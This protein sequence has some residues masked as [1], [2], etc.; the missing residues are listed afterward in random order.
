[1]RTTAR[2]AASGGRTVSRDPGETSL[3]AT[4]VTGR[5]PV[6]ILGRVD[7]LFGQILSFEAAF[8]LFLYSNELKTIIPFP[9]GKLDETVVF[10]AL[11]VGAAA[12]VIY[13]E[14][15]YLRGIP[16]LSAVLVF[17]GWAVLSGL[18]WSPS[19]T[20][21]WK[22]ISYLLTF[23]TFS[24]VAGCLII[25]NRRE[26]AVRFF[27]VALVISA[28]MA[29]YGLYIDFAFGNF[30]RWAGWHDV[31]GRTYLAFGH[32][33]VNGA[34]VAFCIAIFSRLGSIRQAAGVALFGA[35]LLFL[36]VGGGRG[37][38]LGAIL[39]AMV[40]LATRPPT[41]TRGRFEVPHATMIA[42]GMLTVA[43]GYIG[44]ILLSGEMTSTL[45]RFT[46]LTEQVESRGEDSGPNRMKY[47]LTAYKLWLSAPMIGH[48]LNSFSVLYTVGHKETP[49]SHPHDIFLQIASEMGIVG[50][51][52]IAA[53]MWTG[54]RFCTV[55][56]LR[57]DPLLVCAL[58]FVI[59]SSM[60]ALFGRDIV[61]SRKFFFALSLLALRPP[62][63]SRQAVSEREAD[64][65]DKEEVPSA[66][67]RLGAPAAA[68]PV[69]YGPGGAG[70]IS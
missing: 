4:L 50:L 16:V 1:M 33:V 45:S 55:N 31:D 30:R 69:G 5:R 29:L 59:T 44:Y 21:V 51:F 24:V 67:R 12:I 17:I 9:F 20:L 2:G 23:T 41:V 11:A 19:R 34:G 53:F 52:L 39:A 32:T 57:R 25:A 27:F 46:N 63:P 15:I 8:A 58:L 62:T 18:V 22:S 56:R 28:G 3:I 54:L 64:E 35:C 48:G 49:S 6:G 68:R 26:R 43:A 13:R 70:A 47:W 60:S 61:G 7:W 65:E 38:F 66:P 40:A 36:L 42:A 37:P 10:G 14:G